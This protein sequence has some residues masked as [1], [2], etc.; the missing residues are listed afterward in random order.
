[1]RL[2]Y[3][4]FAVNQG[5]DVT[6][7]AMKRRVSQHKLV[8]HCNTK[9]IFQCVAFQQSSVSLHKTMRCFQQRGNR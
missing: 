2:C 1:M 8:D 6:V 9:E 7:Y 3:R 5:V 4:L